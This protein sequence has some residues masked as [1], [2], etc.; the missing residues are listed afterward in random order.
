MS[1]RAYAKAQAQQKTLIGP[2]SSLV[3]V[4][5]NS[6]AKENVP[7][8]NSAFGRASRFGHDFSRVP[9]HSLQ[10]S[11]PQMKLEVN[12]PGDVYEQEADQVTEQLMRM[13]D[14][15]PSVSDDEDE[16]KTSLM[17]KQSSEPQAD[18]GADISSVPL[19]VH[20]VLNSGGGQPLDTTTRAFM[21]PRFG[22]DFSRV[23]IHTDAQAAESARTVNA[24]A[25]TVGRD[26]VFG[27]RQYAPQNSKGRRLLA[28]ELTHVVQQNTNTDAPQLQRKMV[29]G[30]EKD[31]EAFKWFLTANDAQNFSFAGKKG[32]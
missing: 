17:L 29:L 19:V 15:G 16:A 28:H 32:K 10:T 21:E 24:L 6:L 27:A 13:P 4:Q 8:F 26:V 7:S 30:S 18:T 3:T 12:Q 20:A 25:Y 14:R 5:G 9:I 2:P 22:H 11:V 31:A 1:D 23:R